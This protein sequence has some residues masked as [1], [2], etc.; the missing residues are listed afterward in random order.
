VVARAL[1]RTLIAA[2]VLAA[3]AILLAPPQDTF[4]LA[5]TDVSSSP[6]DQANE[7]KRLRI[8]LA[9]AEAVRRDLEAKLDVLREPAPI[10]SEKPKLPGLWSDDVV[11]LLYKPPEWP[12]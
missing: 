4:K 1:E 8:E 6:V 10:A 9:A 5:S 7:I 3:G 11:G 12:R 2:L